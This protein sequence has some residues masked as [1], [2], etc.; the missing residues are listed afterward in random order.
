MKPQEVYAYRMTHDNGF[1]P[2]PYYERLTLACCK[3]TMRKKIGKRWHDNPEGLRNAGIYLVG[4]A[5]VKLIEGPKNPRK[6]TKKNP[7]NFLKRKI[8]GSQI[9]YIAQ[10][11]DILTFQE[12]WDKGESWT[13]EKKPHGNLQERFKSDSSALDAEVG[14]RGDNVYNPAFS[15][16]DEIAKEPLSFHKKLNQS[17]AESRTTDLSGEYVLVSD[18]FVYF[19]DCSKL[20]TA[21]NALF[22]PVEKQR[23]NVR[24]YDKGGNTDPKGHY[25]CKGVGHVTMSEEEAPENKEGD[26]FKFIEKWVTPGEGKIYG[27]PISLN[28]SNHGECF[29]CSLMEQCALNHAPATSPMPRILS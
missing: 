29:P 9:I 8:R 26:L 25:I 7:K 2:N 21:D 11:T 5:G 13:E 24:L 4:I 14:E 19:G 6:T 22:E 20:K 16:P 18:T 10:V 3:K 27:A 15:E 28:C 17:N 23:E 12:Y 1:A